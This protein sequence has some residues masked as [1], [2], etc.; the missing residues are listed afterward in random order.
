SA[1]PGIN[2][3]ALCEEINSIAPKAVI[4]N[5]QNLEEHLNQLIG[6]DDV[7]LAQGAG[8][9]SQIITNLIQRDRPA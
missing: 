5:E 6:T 9:I 4:V 1:I 7:I 8:T 3:E 2:S